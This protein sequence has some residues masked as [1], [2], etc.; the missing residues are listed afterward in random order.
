MVKVSTFLPWDCRNLTKGKVYLQ[1]LQWWAETASPGG[2]R[3][4]VSKNLGATMDVP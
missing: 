3:V 4:K 1:P 2:D